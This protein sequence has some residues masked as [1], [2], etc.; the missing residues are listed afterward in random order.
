MHQ[1]QLGLIT[2]GR[3][4]H[5]PPG[6]KAAALEAETFGWYSSQRELAGHERGREAYARS[7]K[8]AS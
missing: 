4:K 8:G 6:S 3:A 7:R 2:L 1:Q 5:L